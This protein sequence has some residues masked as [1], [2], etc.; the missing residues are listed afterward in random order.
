MENQAADEPAEGEDILRQ[1]MEHALGEL[2]RPADGLF[3]SAFSA[4]LDIGFGPLLMGAVLTAAAPGFADTLSGMLLLGI[5]YG[6]GFIF[7]VLGRS[8]LFTEHTTL[9]VLPVLDGQETVGRLARLWAIVYSANIVGAVGF[10]LVIATLAP[11]TELVDP[12]AFVT[13]AKG[14]TKY[15]WEVIVTG[16]V[17]AGWLMGLLSWLVSAADDTLSRMAVVW[18]VTASIGIIHLPHSIAGTIEVLPAAIVSPEVTFADFGR[19]LAASTVGNAIGGSV[20]VGLL[21]YGHVVRSGPSGEV[22]RSD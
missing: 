1:Q 13:I 12:G 9:A 2:R 14:F 21:K 11:A 22:V 6:V 4:G 10:S 3:L 5:V 17:L 15:P 7:V 20:F 19:F 18:I 16:G 8:E